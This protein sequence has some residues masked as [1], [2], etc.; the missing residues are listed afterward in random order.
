MAVVISLLIIFVLVIVLVVRR[1]NSFSLRHNTQFWLIAAYILLLLASPAL[2]KLLPVENLADEKMKT[3]SG[4]D[5]AEAMF[6]ERDLYELA[7]EGRPEQ[8]KGAFVLE[9][10]EFPL[11]SSLINVAEGSEYE[12]VTTIIAEKKDSADG[13]IEVINYATKT[14][15][16]QF[17]FSEEMMPHKVAF[18]GNILKVSGPECQ[19]V[20][21]AM[22]SREFVVS[23]ILGDSAATEQ[24]YTN[25]FGS[26]LLYLRIPADVEVQSKTTIHFVE[27]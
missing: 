13:K 2:I 17:D 25:N 18:N 4:K 10:W 24:H 7:I 14:I 1:S 15:I 19:E 3:V 26:Q 6:S 8:V 21:L 20:G 27:S 5:I 9:Q 23:Q 16:D 12:G 11:N 22:F